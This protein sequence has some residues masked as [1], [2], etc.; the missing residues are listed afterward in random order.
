[1]KNTTM[2]LLTI[3]PIL[4]LAACS[5][6]NMSLSESDVLKTSEKVEVCNFGLNQFN[7][8][9]RAVMEV[10][11]AQM[12]SPHRTAPVVVADATIFLDFDGETV[13]N[14][15]WNN[16]GAINSAPANLQI[17]EIEKIISRVSE[18]FSPFNVNVT[19]HESV[20]N[21]TH[22]Q[23]RIRVIITETWEWFGMAG[24]IAYPGSFSWGNNTP[25]F[26]FSSLLFY[27][28][29]F[30]AEA[31]SHEVGHTL[32]LDHQRGFTSNCSFLSEY[33]SG[34]G[35]GLTGWAPIMGNSYYHNV[36]TW[37]NGPTTSCGNLQDDVAILSGILGLKADE[38][39]K[40]N[41]APQ[42]INYSEGMINHSEDEDYFA[43]NLKN[44]ATL[45]ASPHCLGDGMGANLQ[46]KLNIYHKNGNLVSSISDPSSLSAST[47]LPGPS[48]GP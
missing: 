23:K 29:K 22:P 19:T 25:A 26:V 37:H 6:K 45:T 10:P 42:L 34:T 17:T 13:E 9:K 35:G 12:K 32:G 40:M 47:V 16:N 30:I 4:I 38:M 20:Y 28:E 39:D 46:L 3:L 1:M 24:G 14:T 44:A 11:Y 27:N 5:K 33:N 43:V 48:S 18:D 8:V 36:T 15:I 2:R 41:R 21:N 7:M 31:I